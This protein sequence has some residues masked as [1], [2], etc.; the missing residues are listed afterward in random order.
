MLPACFTRIPAH[1]QLSA[2]CLKT[3]ADTKAASGWVDAR[4]PPAIDWACLKHP[5]DVGVLGAGV[6]VLKKVSS[7]QHLE[8]EPAE[9]KVPPSEIDLSDTQRASNTVKHWV[10]GEYHP[11]GSCAMGVVVA[12]RLKSRCSSGGC[13]YPPHLGQWQYCQLSICCGRESCRH[14]QGRLRED[15]FKVD[16]EQT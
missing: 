8:N 13:Q 1:H 11:A 7:S 2:I 3:I 4:Q 12:S 14:L 6:K 9:R 5:A 10:L 15:V 16:Y